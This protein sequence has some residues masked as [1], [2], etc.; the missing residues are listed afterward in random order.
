MSGHKT[1]I[2]KIL[3]AVDLGIYTPHLLQ[4]AASLSSQYNAS[5][6]VV[7]AVEPLGTL[8][9]AL[10]Q[11]YLK[12]E[13]TKEITT[14]GMDSVVDQIRTQVID[15]LTDEFMSG[16]IDLPRLENVIVRP[17]MPVDVILDTAKDINADVIVLG[18]HSSE[19]H[20]S[21]L[22]TVPQ[23]VLSHSKWPVYLIP[24]PNPEPLWQGR[25][26]I[27]PEARM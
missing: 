12:P 15:I 27:G 19:M 11:T 6:V 8:G 1:V 22:G 18:S 24:Q 2:K 14:V 9:H 5:M 23:K 13:A 17:G 20:D 4:H 25:Q 16:G 7:H 3:L 21:N 10:L 26:Y